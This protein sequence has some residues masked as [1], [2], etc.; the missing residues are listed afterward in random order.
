[1]IAVWGLDLNRILQ[2]FN[3]RSATFT[4]MLLIIPFQ[5]ELAIN[6]HITVSNI[7]RD[8]SKIQE[9]IGSR[10]PLVSVDHIQSVDN[11]KVLTVS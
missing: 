11:M 1:M 10:I 4:W 3:V 7:H 9:E 2:V 8:V 6:T 5:T